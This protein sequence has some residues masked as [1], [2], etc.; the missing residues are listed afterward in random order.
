[1]D[2]TIVDE[3]L[4]PFYADVGRGG[5]QHF[6][7][8]GVG[9]LQKLIDYGVVEMGQWNNCG[10]VHRLF[11]PFLQ[12]NPMFDAHGYVVTLD[13]TTKRVVVEGVHYAAHPA[14]TISQVID[15]ANT[16]RNADEF[17]LDTSRA[18]CWYD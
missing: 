4:E 1:M 18:Q 15:F 6:D 10:G 13:D 17:E 5:I 3:F 12:R 2:K 9:L 7:G 8:I 11:L 14:I 16:F